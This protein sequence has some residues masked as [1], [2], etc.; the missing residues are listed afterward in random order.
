[1]SRASRPDGMRQAALRLPKRWQSTAAPVHWLSQPRLALGS[2]WLLVSLDPSWCCL[3]EGFTGKAN[4]FQMIE[5]ANC[6]HC[7]L[8]DAYIAAAA[9]S[10]IS[11][12]TTNP[13]L[14]DHDI[15]ALRVCM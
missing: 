10:Y 11:K 14:T 4:S 1:M 6:S 2:I 5:Y 9:Y 12:H 15:A 3:G 13:P 8:A 7:W